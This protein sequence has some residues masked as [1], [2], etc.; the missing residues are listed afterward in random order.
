MH[1]NA[2]ENARPAG[3]RA[4]LHLAPAGWV[5]D[6]TM[7]VWDHDKAT[8]VSAALPQ[9]TVY[10]YELVDDQVKVRTVE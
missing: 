4:G 2:T 5:C 6:I 7:W 10:V 8:T 3:G 9:A 1:Y